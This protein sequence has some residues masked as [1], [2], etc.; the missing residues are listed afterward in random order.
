MYNNI[1]ELLR[2]IKCCIEIGD[3]HK[4]ES[5]TVSDNDNNNNVARSD[6]ELR[7]HNW[8]L[9]RHTIQICQQWIS[10][11]A[12][13][14]TT[15]ILCS[16]ADSTKNLAQTNVVSQQIYKHHPATPRVFRVDFQRVANKL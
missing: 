10:V 7:E 14:R 12:K 6:T 1:V 15:D 5:Q 4:S 2:L 13:K 9:T 16:D 11:L 3:K 8:T